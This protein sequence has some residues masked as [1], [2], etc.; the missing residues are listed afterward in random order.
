M[1]AFSMVTDFSDIDSTVEVDHPINPHR[2]AFAVHGNA[3]RI[4]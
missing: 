4:P 2:G 3:L 1:W